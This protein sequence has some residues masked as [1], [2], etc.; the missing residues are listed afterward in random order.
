MWSCR[1]P[2]AWSPRLGWGGLSGNE[3]A[4]EFALLFV[5]NPSPTLLFITSIKI[6]WFTTLDTG[7]KVTLV[8]HGLSV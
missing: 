5:G 7:A 4:F 3:A 1:A 8:C 6:H 2:A